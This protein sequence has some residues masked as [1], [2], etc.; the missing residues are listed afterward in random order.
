MI[1]FV[2]QG[3]GRTF[4]DSSYHLPAFYELWACWG[5]ENDRAF[6]AAADTSQ[7]YFVNATHPQTGLSSDYADFDGKPIKVPFNPNAHHFAYDFWRTAMNWS[8]DWAW[9]QLDTREQALSNRIQAFFAAQ[10]IGEY[11][12]VY[13]VDGQH[14]GNYQRTG[15]VATNATASLAA[16]HPLAQDFVEALWQEPIPEQ[17]GERYYDGLLYLMSL[18]HCSGQFRIYAPQ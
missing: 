17:T 16:T 18:L 6:W 8:V 3:R 7:A 12:N 5:P 11:G 2:P 9:W 13:T 14:L 1:L 4:S 10:G 15:L